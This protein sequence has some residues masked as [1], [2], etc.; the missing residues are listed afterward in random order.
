MKQP[1]SELSAIPKS[2]K[3][4][5]VRKYDIHTGIDLHCKEGSSVFA[6]EDGVVY[7]VDLFTGPE[8]GSPWW[9]KTSYIG[10]NGKT[11]YIVYGE[12]ISLVSEGQ[13]IKAGDCIGLVQQ[14]LKK[15]KNKPQS[16][17]HLELYSQPVE[18]PVTWNLNEQMPGHLL[19]PTSIIER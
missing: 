15:D 7:K 8:A 11:G 6:I 12:V 16:M 4:G 13:E 10:I 5:A 9:N 17:L 19:D 3:F 18:S 1:L 14:V 2:A